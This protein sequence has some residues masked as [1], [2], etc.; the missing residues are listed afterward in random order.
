MNVCEAVRCPNQNILFIVAD[1]LGYAELSCCGQ[2]DF[3]TPHLDKLAAEGTRFT[4]AYAASPLC[5][6]REFRGYLRTTGI[7]ICTIYGTLLQCQPR[8]G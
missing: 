4:Q 8:N 1:D 5:T 2:T 3:T 6:I 7:D